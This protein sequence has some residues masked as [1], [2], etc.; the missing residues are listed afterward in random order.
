MFESLSERSFRGQAN[1]LSTTVEV[2]FEGE[3]SVDMIG[4]GQTG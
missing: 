3:G 2:S 4:G 1:F